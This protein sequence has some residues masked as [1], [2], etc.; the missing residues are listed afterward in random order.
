MLS[1]AAPLN[2]LFNN[3]A[4]NV[5]ESAKGE[6]CFE[7]GSAKHQYDSLNRKQWMEKFFFFTFLVE[8]KRGEEK[9]ENFEFKKLFES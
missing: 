4:S 1:V 7:E 9:R 8:V 6:T 2:Q 3:K 5:L